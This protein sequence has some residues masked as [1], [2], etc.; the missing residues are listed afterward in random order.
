MSTEDGVIAIIIGRAGSR[1][2]P[3]K[4][5]RPLLGRPMIAWTIDDARAARSVGRIVVSTDGDDIAAAAAAL[6]V[7]VVRRPAELA[8]DTAPVD[9]AV[10][11]AVEASGRAAEIVVILYANVPV[12]PA[13]LIDTAVARLLETGADSVQSYARVGKH[14]PYWMA[15]LDSAGRVAP[16]HP[17]TI[18]RRQDLPPLHLPDGGVIAV[19]RTSLGTT[20]PGAPHAFLGTD[21]RGI[22]TP[23]GAVVDVDGPTDLAVAETLLRRRRAVEAAPE[24]AE[25]PA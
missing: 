25:I 15:S 9:A 5:A 3:G 11:H 13:G 14:H 7:E 20:A 1:G 23:D 10:R 8:T 24:P 21:R 17:N 22:E 2:L 4:N 16:H 12:R 19:T 6:G 18:H